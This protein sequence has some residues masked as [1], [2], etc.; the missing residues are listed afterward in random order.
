MEDTFDTDM[1]DDGY[2]GLV[3]DIMAHPGAVELFR[4][5]AFAG[6]FNEYLR[7]AGFRKDGTN[8]PA[9]SASFRAIGDIIGG[10]RGLGEPYVVFYL[11]SPPY[12]KE[13]TARV[14][15]FLASIGWHRLSEQEIAADHAKAMALLEELEARPVGVVPLD[16]RIGLSTERDKVARPQSLSGRMHIASIDGQ[17]TA[18]EHHRFFAL[19]DHGQNETPT[20]SV[21]P[22]P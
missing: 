2:D 17:A 4:D 6:A 15:T 18:E 13:D 10:I 7:N 8:D 20:V 19:Y 11:T 22:G 21:P 9:W 3:A 1:D 5:D 12:T 16:Q 14:E